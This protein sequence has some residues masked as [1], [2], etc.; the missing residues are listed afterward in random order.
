MARAN[1]TNYVEDDATVIVRANS[2]DAWLFLP[3]C[4]LFVSGLGYLTMLGPEGIAASHPNMNFNYGLIPIASAFAI[5]LLLAKLY[6]LVWPTRYA[7]H[8]TPEQI[9]FYRSSLDEAEYLLRR[10][11]VQSVRTRRRRWFHNPDMCEPIEFVD[12]FGEV[13]TIPVCYIWTG[14]RSEFL[15]LVRDRWGPTFV[16]TNTDG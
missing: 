6:Q 13:T 9:A 8:V 4:S 14:N 3:V 10:D 7:T 2:D 16:T 11:S 5:V 12:R 15:G 1:E